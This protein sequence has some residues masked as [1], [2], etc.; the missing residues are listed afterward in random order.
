MTGARSNA[1]LLHLDHALAE[2]DQA[3]SVS[4]P[5]V[6]DMRVKAGQI[7]AGRIHIDAEFAARLGYVDMRDSL[8]GV[9]TASIAR[10]RASEIAHRRL[11]NRLFWR[12]VWVRCRAVFW[13][14]LGL[15]MVSGL[16]WTL[17]LW[18]VEILAFLFP[19]AVPNVLTL[20]TAAT[21]GPLQPPGQSFQPALAPYAVGPQ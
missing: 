7:A 16:G 2:A 8:R 15:G 1:A 14:F 13:V 6:P 12:L 19:P 17:W 21:N 10:A 4:A 9:T 11:R 5:S 3:F 20:P 18:H